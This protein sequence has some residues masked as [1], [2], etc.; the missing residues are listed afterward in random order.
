MSAWTPRKI[1]RE[2]S[3]RDAA[4]PPAGLLGRIKNEIP[5]DLG[6]RLPAAALREVRAAEVVSLA[7]RRRLRRQVRLLA[8]S[9]I[10]T[11]TGGLIAGLVV[12]R[13]TPPP[14]A[15][16]E[17]ELAK[18]APARAGSP[19][20]AAPAPRRAA[21]PA[22]LRAVP[23]EPPAAPAPP[24]PPAASQEADLKSLG[25]V[26]DEAPKKEAADE[27]KEM[28]P[29]VAG[30]SAPAPEAARAVPMEIQAPAVES[31]AGGGVPGGVVGGEAAR[32][33]FALRT[34]GAAS[35]FTPAPGTCL[36]RIQALAEDAEV[37]VE[38]V[39]AA[40]ARWRLVGSES[41]GRTRL[42]EVQLTPPAAAN[43]SAK[44]ADLRLHGETVRELR[45]SDLVGAWDGAS[46]GFRLATL[47]AAWDEARRG[48]S[49]AANLERI[50]Q[51][52]RKLAHE[53][54]GQ[55]GGAEAAEL[56]RRVEAA[57]KLRER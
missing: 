2:L 55:P 7:E 43:P 12:M 56:V 33:D 23:A 3:E 4:E 47:T 45:V 39:P 15:M 8:A 24:P 36:L 35:V 41:G 5:A 49:P 54:A 34:E 53:T 18:E 31:G 40:V 29:R 21:P 32:G 14:A 19:E 37:A 10:L 30:L 46:P 57:A 16:V 44:V 11:V 20:T 28:R 1:A 26:R 25:D 27:D 22:S 48:A 13:Q 9:L 42:Y 52:A 38:L 17:R 51:L 6:S 50:L